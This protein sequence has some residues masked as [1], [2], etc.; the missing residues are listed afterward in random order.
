MFSQ[1]VLIS[2]ISFQFIY[3]NTFKILCNQLLF[4]ITHALSKINN[5]DICIITSCA[6]PYGDKN[7]L[8]AIKYFYASKGPQHFSRL[9]SIPTPCLHIKAYINCSI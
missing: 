7:S 3:V 5:F 9:N 1:I 8:L 6:H 4:L 2:I